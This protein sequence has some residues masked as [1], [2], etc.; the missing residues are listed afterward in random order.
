VWN[1]DGFYDNATTGTDLGGQNGT[2][3]AGSLVWNATEKLSFRLRAEVLDD[4]F[5]PFPYRQLPGNTLLPV[6]LAA[7]TPLGGPGTS[8]V[9]PAV[10]QV[11]AWVGTLPDGASLTPGISPNPRGGDYPGTERDITRFTL[12]GKYDFDAVSLTYLGHVANAE[13]EQFYDSVAIGNSAVEFVGGEIIYDDETDLQSHELRLT[14]SGD[15]TVDWVAGGLYW[16]EE[17]DFNDGGFNC[18]NN[19]N[20]STNPADLPYPPCAS[21]IASVSVRGSPGSA[22]NPDFWGRDTEHYSVYGLVDW[23]FRE[24][25][26]LILEGRYTWEDL[27][28]VGPNRPGQA[29]SRIIG[30]LFLVA[31]PFPPFQVPLYPQVLPAN[32]GLIPASQDDDFFSP[33]ATLQWRPTDDSMVYF[34]WAQAAK[35]AGIALLTGGAAGFNPKEQSF[36]REEMQVWELGAKSAWLDQRLTLNGAVFFQDY[37]DKQV[38]VQAIDEVTGLVVPRTTNAASAE[39]WGLE[40]DT[41]WAATD[42]LSLY[43]SYTFLDT[44]YADFTEVT[45]G[46]GNIAQASVRRPDNCTAAIPEGAGPSVVRPSCFMDLSGNELEY[47]PRHALVVGFTLEAPL[48]GELTGFFE[49]NGLYQDERFLDRFNVAKLDSYTVFDFRLGI[50]TDRWDVLAYMDN[51]FNDETIK[52]GTSAVLTRDARSVAFPGPFTF[53]IPPS[54]LTVLPDQRQFGIRASFRFGG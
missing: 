2:A 12:T 49:G 50:R 36:E 53:V 23:E 27:D 45:T 8:V 10:T 7:R 47:A 4:E 33:K 22:L 17:V 21:R 31:V 28:V 48:S 15:N 5:D 52:T 6:P 24:R 3:Y 37:S 51:A 41:Q 40:F 29:D 14:S 11:N 26:N 16:K 32:S 20:L 25:F 35:P 39:V 43:A 38:S 1:H 42:N 18:I 44:E 13:T 9:S 34:S 54:V 46:A 30:D 19:R